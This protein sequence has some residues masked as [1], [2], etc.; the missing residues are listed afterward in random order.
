LSG[1]MFSVTYFSE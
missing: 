1:Y